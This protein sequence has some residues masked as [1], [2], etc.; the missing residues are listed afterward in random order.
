[1]RSSFV[2]DPLRLLH[3][4]P[5]TD[6]AAAVLLCPLSEAKRFTD[7]PVKIRGSGMATSSL[8]L[9]ERQNPAVLDAVQ[10][11]A[12]R[13][14]KASGV[15]P[16]DIDVAEVHDCFSIA[17]ICCIEALGFVDR[18]RGG[19]A[20]R[21]GMTALGGK[22]PVNTSGGLKSKGHPV[23]TTGV[24]QA[25]EIF[26]QLRGDSGARQVKGARI[27]LTQNMGGSGASSVVHIYERGF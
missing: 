13:A 22:I 20:A 27:G 7:R 11:A 12:E 19:S 16:G 1:M 6:G 23:G 18:G 26:E 9:A 21:S 10:L 14:Y 24:A 3:C 4:S 2:A 25:I 17:E 15:G 8:A 5:V